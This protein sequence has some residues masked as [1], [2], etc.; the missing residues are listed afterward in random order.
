MKSIIHHHSFTVF[1]NKNIV[2]EYFSHLV[3]SV[4]VFYHFL[5]EDSNPEVFEIDFQFNALLGGIIYY[6]YYYYSLFLLQIGGT[7][8]LL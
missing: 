2:A 5:R 1:N 8:C 4:E 7:G 6:Y 3:L